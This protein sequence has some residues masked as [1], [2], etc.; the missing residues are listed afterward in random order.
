MSSPLKVWLERDGHLLRLRLDRPKANILDAAMVGAIENAIRGVRQIESHRAAF[1]MA[2]FHYFFQREGLARVELNAR[3][4]DQRDAFTFA[5][6]ELQ[7]IVHA[8]D[9]LPLPR[10]RLDQRSIGIEAVKPDLRLHRVTVGREGVRLDE[11]L[12]AFGRGPVKAHHEEMEVRRQ[13]VH[14]RDF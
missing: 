1:S 13:G 2:G 6:D 11:N 12:V 5:V 8:D 10:L 7:E 3:P 14:R 9:R 4:E